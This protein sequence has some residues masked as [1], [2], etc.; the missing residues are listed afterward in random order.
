M[1][2]TS[3][4]IHKCVLFLVFVLLTQNFFFDIYRT[5]A[6]NTTPHDDYTPYLLALLGEEGGGI[7]GSPHAYRLFSVALAIPFYHTL[8]FYRF[9]YAEAENATYLMAV[10]ALSAVSYLAM[11]M[12]SA[13]LYRITR[14]RLGGTELPSMTVMLLSFLFFKHMS[15]Y[16]IDA[17]A[18]MLICAMLYALPYPRVFL[19]LSVLS[20]G[21]NEKIVLLFVL[22]MGSRCLFRKQQCMPH[23]VASILSLV[24]YLGMILFFRIPGNENQLDIQTYFSGF[25]LNVGESL[26][27][28]GLFLNVIPSVLLLCLYLLAAKEHTARAAQHTL[29]FTPVD[30]VPLLGL[31][32]F[33][34]AVKVHYNVG[35]I[36]MYCFPLYLPLATLS[37]K[38]LLE[39]HE[40]GLVNH[41]D[42]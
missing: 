24:V 7:P 30:I 18:V 12:S 25:L 33:S 19:L 20:A 23:F 22:L 6:F 11:L 14:Y 21:C 1:T 10:E 8:P 28:K 37:V 5:V 27:L 40:G 16:D 39:N 42:A 4:Y 29:Y 26:S 34:H 31:I 38:S 2:I 41:D 36:A 17:I 9:R 3:Q 15:I 32:V 13:L 35:R